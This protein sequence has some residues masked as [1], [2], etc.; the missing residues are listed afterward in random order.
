MQKPT[1]AIDTD[2]ARLHEL[3]PET[4]SILLDLLPCISGAPVQHSI[5]PPPGAPRSHAVQNCYRLR[6]EAAEQR[7]AHMQGLVAASLEELHRLIS[8]N[9][10]LRA[11]RLIIRNGM[12]LDCDATLSALLTDKGM[13]IAL[14]RYSSIASEFHA[15]T[16]RLD[17]VLDEND[18][19]SKLNREL[20][21]EAM[22]TVVE[23][24]DSPD[25]GM[26]QVE[27]L[28]VEIQTLRAKITKLELECLRLQS[29][30]T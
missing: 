8:E 6:L 16:T 7:Y 5:H 1:N 14:P 25:V 28:M 21:G 29:T 3:C 24:I 17:A 2:F 19:L 26:T 22:A 13:G 23:H 18:K 11:A 20:R 30:D 10:C 9:K 12:E 27:K 15:L 4:L